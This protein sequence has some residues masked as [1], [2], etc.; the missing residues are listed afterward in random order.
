M[1]S[2]IKIAGTINKYLCC[3]LLLTMVGF[4]FVNTALRYF[5]SSGIIIIVDVA[6]QHS[7]Q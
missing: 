4:V 6:F 7:A 5:F 3:A 2:V 1:E